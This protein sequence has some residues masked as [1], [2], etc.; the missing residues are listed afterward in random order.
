MTT[1]MTG[2][3]ERVTE[4]ELGAWRPV[5]G[6]GHVGFEVRTMWGLATVRGRFDRYDGKL[7][8]GP[9]RISAELTVDTDSVNTAKANRDR[10]L[11]S[12][13]F[14][15]AERYPAIT[16][17]SRAITATP[18]GLLIDGDLT[19]GETTLRRELEAELIRDETGALV[20]YTETT[21]DRADAKLDWNRLGMIVGD[22]LLRV[23]LELEQ[24]REGTTR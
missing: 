22:A 16:F 20:L 21:I 24:E 23:E 9:E 8:V 13:D 7:V 6:T 14:F 11:R 3:P 18:D 17:R 4:L 19:I 12:A 1:T 15:D 10:H 2:G 5:P